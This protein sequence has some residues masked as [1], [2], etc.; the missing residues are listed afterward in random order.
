MYDNAIITKVLEEILEFD[1][2]NPACLG[3][4]A[5]RGPAAAPV[6]ITTQYKGDK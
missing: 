3:C 5:C 4:G 1:P 6:S 2:L